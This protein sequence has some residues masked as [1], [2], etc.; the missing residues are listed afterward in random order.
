[1][2]STTLAQVGECY[3]REAFISL[4]VE[5]ITLHSPFVRCTGREWATRWTILAERIWSFSYLRN[6]TPAGR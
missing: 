1:M 6:V 5:L 2:K 4:S 3:T